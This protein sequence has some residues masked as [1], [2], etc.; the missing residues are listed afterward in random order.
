MSL[1][2]GSNTFGS[3]KGLPDHALPHFDP[4]RRED[5]NFKDAVRI[6]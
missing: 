1:P 5:L 3:W 4:I 6:L 2:A